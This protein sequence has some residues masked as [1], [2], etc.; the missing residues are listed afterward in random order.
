MMPVV[1]ARASVWQRPQLLTKRTFPSTRL[2]FCPPFS[3]QPP[4]TSASAPI[5]AAPTSFRLTEPRSA[6]AAR[7]LS[8]PAA[9]VLWSVPSDLMSPGDRYRLRTPS[10]GRELIVEAQP[11]K[12]YTDRDPGEPLEVVGRVLPLAP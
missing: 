6:I 9:P 11:G 4:A 8:E 12:L 3:A 10:N 7:T 1:C 5:A 2:T